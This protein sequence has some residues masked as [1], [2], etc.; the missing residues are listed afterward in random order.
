MSGPDTTARGARPP[1]IAIGGFFLEAN[2][3]APTTGADGF[4]QGFDAAG[5]ALMAELRSSSTRL[6]GDSLGF[7][8]A[9]DQAGD[10]EPVPLRMAGAEPGGPADH[11]F[12]DALCAN[13]DAR[14]KLAGP[15]DGVFLS[16]HGAALTTRDDDPDG[17][18]LARLR[19]RVGPSV[20]IVA[21][22]DLHANVS[23]RMAESLSGAVAYRTNPHVDLF[24]RGQE[25][26]RLLRQMLAEGPGEVE[27]VQL[28]LVPS[29][30]SQLIA[31]GTV[32]SD[33]VDEGQ[34]C[35]GGDILNVSLCGGFALADAAKCGFSAVVTARAGRRAAARALAL[36]L[37]A[38]AWASRERFTSRLVPLADAVAAAVAAGEG[39]R[40]PV[41]LA[42][43]GDNP[44][45]GGGG[46]TTTLLRAL[47]EAGATRTVLGV[48]TDASLARQA[49]ALGVGGRF[50]ANFNR[51]R[52]DAFAI[53]WRHPAQVLAVS[54]GSFIGRRGLVQG[55]RREMGPSALL[56][57]GG[58]QVAVISRRQ[59]L[60]DPAQLEALGVDLADIRV[61]VA[62][63]RGHFRAAF[64]G[65]ADP[66][67]ILEAD[68]PGLTTPNLRSLSWT[69]LPRPVYP[70]DDEAAWQPPVA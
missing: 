40:P 69:R 9:M 3:W 39:A 29:A 42:D 37:A 70:L 43:V 49:C 56:Q 51:D 28:P 22:L 35:V 38:S 64:E 32:Y 44:G 20:P 68:C 45:G 12:F 8:T 27:R 54:D 36:R 65:F 47:V 16:M 5:D 57:L 50:E 41:M 61:L 2:R 62:K 7:M 4:R 67:D 52:S 53:A 25:A 17:T 31:P 13:L 10:W 26:A 21:V 23:Q 19:A 59:Q 46:N 58:V 55:T 1:R 63:S 14:L 60:I 48:F 34:R 66:R 30:T 33:L 11:A 15:V 6:L 24:E 18:L